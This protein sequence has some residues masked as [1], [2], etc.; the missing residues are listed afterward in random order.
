MKFIG[1]VLVLACVALVG[2]PKPKP[3]APIQPAEPCMPSK[4]ACM[5]SVGKVS[6]IGTPK[7]WLVDL[8][9][10]DQEGGGELDRAAIIKAAKQCEGPTG[11]G[12]A[13]AKPEVE[14]LLGE[15]ARAKLEQ[16][17][18]PGVAAYRFDQQKNILQITG[19]PERI[20][21]VVSGLPPLAQ[22]SC[23]HCGLCLP[24]QCEIP[25]P[26]PPRFEDLRITPPMRLPIR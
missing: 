9:G 11:C 2:C 14:A 23:L 12:V 6:L 18:I 5:V 16:L 13:M 20:G 10:L 3:G 8:R 17:S 21:D 19:D 1:L 7:L 15:L 25:P 26:I 24:G 4:S 22:W